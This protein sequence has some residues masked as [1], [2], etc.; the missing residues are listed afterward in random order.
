MRQI[1]FISAAEIAK[2]IHPTEQEKNRSHRDA[3]CVRSGRTSAKPTRGFRSRLN[4][5]ALAALDEH[6]RDARV[7]QLPDC[8]V[9]NKMMNIHQRGKNQEAHREIEMKRI[10]HQPRSRNEKRDPTG[11]KRE[12]VSPH[13]P[14]RVPCGPRFAPRV[15]TGD[16]EILRG[17]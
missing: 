9:Q 2:L 4:F 17:M 15:V 11:D 10:T 5:T 3:K 7:A 6:R 16:P 13:A 1:A 12:E 8:P 14:R